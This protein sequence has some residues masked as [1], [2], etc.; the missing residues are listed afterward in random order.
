LQGRRIFSP[1]LSKAFLEDCQKQIVLGFLSM[2]NNRDGDI[3]LVG[4][5]TNG[6]CLE[7]MLVLHVSVRG[8]DRAGAMSPRR[9]DEG[10][11]QA[12]RTFPL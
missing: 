11:F 12:L 3:G 9:I 10:G 7:P 5:I 6:Y 1:D 4:N 8:S 2:V